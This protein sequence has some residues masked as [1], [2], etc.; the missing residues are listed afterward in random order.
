VRFWTSAPFAAALLAILAPA[1]PAGADW[2][3]SQD[4]APYGARSLGQTDT[5]RFTKSISYQLWRAGLGGAKLDLFPPAPTNTDGWFQ[6]GPPMLVRGLN[7]RSTDYG[8]IQAH[9]DQYPYDDLKPCRTTAFQRERMTPDLVEVGLHEAA[10]YASFRLGLDQSAYAAVKRKIDAYN[11][12]PG[13]EP[14]YKVQVSFQ[15]VREDVA[16]ASAI[17]YIYSNYDDVAANDAEAQAKADMR[18]SAFFDSEHETSNAIAAARA[19]FL[20][21]PRRGLSIVETT[22][23]AAEIVTNEPAQDLDT[24]LQAA[25]QVRDPSLGDPA[26]EA[27]LAVA[28]E[29]FRAIRNRFCG[30]SA[31]SPP[32]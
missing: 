9:M 5:A 11:A 4:M 2:Y 12:S 32:A 23:L 25:R 26:F 14:A 30:V 15:N 8:E 22:R 16:D 20:R 3:G 10:H 7:A 18:V 24:R 27:R 1:K 6:P 29:R 31:A 21:N 13:V 28:Y 17:L 19:A